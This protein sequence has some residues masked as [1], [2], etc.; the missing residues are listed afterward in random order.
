MTKVE[1]CELLIGMFEVCIEYLHGQVAVSEY[2][3]IDEEG[4]YIIDENGNK[5]R[6][7]NN[8]EE[9]EERIG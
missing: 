6:L 1:L 5:I 8:V 2:Y 7:A 3:L 4:R 9:D